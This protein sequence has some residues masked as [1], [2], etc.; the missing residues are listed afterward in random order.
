MK[1]RKTYEE[2][3]IAKEAVREWATST[4]KIQDI[5]NELEKLGAKKND[6]NA[7]RKKGTLPE[8]ALDRVEKELSNRIEELLAIYEHIGAKTKTISNVM[9]KLEPEEIA[10]LK[11]KYSNDRMAE[12]MAREMYISR[13]TFFRWQKKIIDKVIPLMK[14]AGWNF[15]V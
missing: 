2:E 14:D 9:L 7:L 10:F 4:R 11:F 12:E 13:A 8:E 6:L 15:E 1:D 5:L 3:L